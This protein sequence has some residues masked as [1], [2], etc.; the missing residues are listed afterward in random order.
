M[1]E[2]LNETSQ[3]AI[4]DTYFEAL[5]TLSSSRW[6]LYENRTLEKPADFSDLHEIYG[7]LLDSIA[8]K[9]VLKNGSI[10]VTG[11]AGSGKSALV[12][13]ITQEIR[14]SS[15]VVILDNFLNSSEGTPPTLY[16]VYVSSIHQIISQRPSLFRPVQ[17]LM[18]EILRQKIWTVENLGILLAAILHHS[19]AVDFLIIIYDFEDWPN[20]IRSWWSETLG[21]LMKSCV[22]A[23][24]FLTSSHRPI[25]DLTSSKPHELDLKKEY[26]RYKNDFIRAKTNNLLDHAYG[27]VT[28]GKGLSEILK[29]KIISRA[30]SF[31]GSFTAINTY[32]ALLFQSFTLNTLEAI[33]CNIKLSPQT[34]EQL[35]EQEISRLRDKPPIVRSWISSA[36]SWMLWSVRTLRIE[37]LAAAVAVDLDD[38]SMAKIQAMVSMDMERDLRSQLGPVVAIENRYARIA[39]ASARGLLSRNDMRKS[40]DLHSDSSLTT[41]CL[42]YITLILRDKKPET[43]NKCLSQVSWKHQT[44]AS[45]DPALEFLYYAC[46]FWPTHFL[47]VK[48]PDSNLKK[49]VVEFLL[50]PEVG[51]RWFQLYLLCSSQCCDP[52]IGDQEASGPATFVPECE[53]TVPEKAGLVTVNAMIDS[54]DED[55]DAR[56]S[57]VRIASFV[58]LASIIPEILGGF[59]CAKEPKI[60]N[61]RRGYSE[62]AIAFWN[63]GSRY[64]LDCAIS[65]DDD[66]EVKALLVSEPARITKYFP[67]HKAVLAGCLKTAQ[68]IFNLVE[69]PAQVDQEGR[70]PLHLAAIGGSTNMI[71]FLLGKDVSNAQP[72]RKDIPNMIDLQ[73]MN[74]QTP[75][76]IASR[77]GNIEA[78]RLLIES[79]SNLAIYDG[80]GKTALHYAVLNCPEVIADF[81]AQD[82]VHIHDDVGCTPLHIAARSSNVETT[83]IL[84]SAFC[85]LAT[86][87]NAQDGQM[88]TPLH[89]AAG[90]GHKEVVEFLLQYEASPEIR[91]AAAE[92][93]ATRGHLA[94]VKVFIA[95]AKEK[96]GEK[97]GE[98]LLKAASGAGQLLVV[99]YLLHNKLASPDGEELPGPR[100]LSLAASKGHNEVVHILLRYKAAVD[101]EDADRQT[102][103]HHVA[104]SGS[105]YIVDVLLDHQANVNAADIHRNTPLHIAARAGRVNVVELLLKR[106]ANCEACSRTRETALHLAVASPKAVKALLEFKANP[107]AANLFRQTPLH[108][109]T[110]GKWHESAEHLLISGADID[111][112]DDDGKP[113]L[114]HAINQNDL[115]M[116]KLFFEKRPDYKDEDRMHS[117]LNWAVKCSALDVL[118]FMLNLSPESV[119]KRYKKGCT[120]LHKAARFASLEVL[121]FL[122]ESRAE[123]DSLNHLK[124]TPLHVAA[125]AGQVQNMREL[126]RR[127]AK[128][129]QADG[130]GKSSLHIAAEGK[131]VEVVD[132]LLEARATVNKQ[133]KHQKTP[134]YLAAFLG[135]A[136]IVERLLSKEANV[137]LVDHAGWSPLHVAA[138]HLQI[139]KMLIASGAEVNLQKKDLWTPLHL[140][141]FWDSTAVAKFLLKNGAEPNQANFNGETALHL[142]LDSNDLEI[143]AAIL[144]YGADVNKPNNQG[145]TPLHTA[146]IRC[147]VNVV[148]LLLCKE[149]DFKI[150][151]KDGRSC[152]SLAVGSDK[153][154]TLEMLLSEGR[155]LAS[156]AVWGFGDMAAAYWKAIECDFPN[157]LEVLVNKE[158]R[159]L[160]EVSDKGFTGIETCLRSRKKLGD[161]EAVAIRLLKLGADPNPLKRRQ[162]DQES[163]FELGII[164]QRT[165]KVE[166]IVACLELVPKDLFSTP[167]GLGFKE[168][169]IAIELNNWEDF[170]TLSKTDSAMT[171]RDGWSLDHF[172][173]QSAGR[174]PT[175]LR[176]MPPLKPTKTP[177]GLVLPPMWLPL[178]RDIEGH[179]EDAPS[180]LEFSFACE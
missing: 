82:S 89:Y 133:D 118:K 59:V 54:P 137:T 117:T 65:N 149:P 166:F 60:I 64:Y 155:S 71:R 104:K 144:R 128:V 143:V 39:S 57:A 74:L 115:K 145:W 81:A 2:H 56:Q 23:F 106:D 134:L 73:D 88:K 27:S 159:L 16:D 66:S 174:V 123:L 131:N 33:M 175:Q 84:V 4:D 179:L 116:V 20:E 28:F 91:A 180:R 177:T 121:I 138:N 18:V 102:A 94:T 125:S 6:I 46:R 50:A 48:K 68:T 108:I 158:G 9:D 25:N 90:N 38:L 49:T 140:A 79:R 167:C 3:A 119:N 147:A 139:T 105:C 35:Y 78:T 13:L 87:I 110:R 101:I 170:E 100:P 75:L 171:D 1:P 141:T 11:P 98:R 85:H 63:T 132:V 130:A 168:L 17:K 109:A 95:A 99:L 148:Q 36:V 7:L 156:D 26:G 162:A 157:S 14:Q 40:L 22:P 42:G 51:E 151:L 44:L 34:E 83:L 129:D 32:L 61:V 93:A 169:R 164:S 126:I 8:W 161:E 77:M 92:L 21:S 30:K 15:S 41:R 76:I 124:K 12:K 31:Q 153:H 62:R 96:I 146:I 154:E 52:L 80:A 150:K 173:H 69:N 37:E 5:Q 29:K 97:I 10:Q 136:E 160:D 70:T 72:R 55:A 135:R 178:D 165:L 86:V 43:W 53:L 112:Q 120:A 152:L 67:L 47:L 19:R 163:C 122:L 172:I 127:G 111:I 113:S 24:T 58:G 107:D 103:L 176:D 114:Y 142:A 45:R